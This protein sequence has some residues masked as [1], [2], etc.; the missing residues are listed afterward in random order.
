M[1]TNHLTEACISTMDRVLVFRSPR[2]VQLIDGKPRSIPRR[3]DRVQI[4]DV[5]ALQVAT[6]FSRDPSGR[7][8]LHSEASVAAGRSWSLARAAQLIRN[9]ARP[10]RWVALHLDKHAWGLFWA[11]GGLQL[12]RNHL[13]RQAASAHDSSALVPVNAEEIRWGISSRELQLVAITS[14]VWLVILLMVMAGFHHALEQQNRKLELLLQ[15]TSPGQVD[16]MPAQP[17]S[18]GRRKPTLSRGSITSLL[19]ARPSTTCGSSARIGITG[20]CFPTCP[21]SPLTIPRRSSEL[22]ASSPHT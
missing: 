11:G 12:C 16:W 7:L 17:A 20:C 10:Q 18:Q 4:V 14:A 22:P 15:R 3:H 1:A 21:S 6:G 8:L 19:S 13:A 2:D 5:F 9:D